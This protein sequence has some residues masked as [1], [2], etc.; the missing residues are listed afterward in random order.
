MSTRISVAELRS[1]VA[2]RHIPVVTHSGKVSKGCVFVVMPPSTP[3]GKADS[4]PG[5]ER[6]L[7]EVLKGS[8]GAVLC[9]PKHLPLLETLGAECDVAVTESMRPALGELATAYYGTDAHCP[10]VVGITGTN[11]KTTETYLMEALFRA[12]DRKVG[13]I[14]TV[15]YRWPGHEEDAPLTTPGCL[16]LH[17]MLA[18]MYTAGAEYAFMEVSSH[19][20]DQERVAGIAF[21]AALLTNLTQD[22]LDYHADMEEYFSAKELLFLS[23][24]EGGVP[25]AGKRAVANADDEYC[26]RLLARE[27]GRIGFGLEREPV[28]GSRH[29]AGTIRSLSPQG[30]RL[31]MRFEGKEWELA[32]PLVGT[33]N[34]MNLL[35]AQA[36]G[37]GLGLAPSDFDALSG[38]TGVAGR[39]ERVPG[40]LGLNVFVDYAHTPDA[41]VKA[42]SALRAAGFERVVTVFGCGGNRDRT[43]RPLMGAAVAQLTD[44]AVLTSDNP[45]DEDPEAILDDVMPGLAEC[46]RVIRQADRRAA[47]AE[48]LALIGPKDAL[49]VAGKGHETYQLIKGVKHPFS[50]Q[51]ILQELMS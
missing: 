44:I 29:L 3:R 10:T 43:K 45:R 15:S 50:D 39:L 48:A 24:A 20:L 46:G 33:F 4:A 34:V 17:A 31:A 37:L 19:A 9:H 16:E 14:G 21:S 2:A 40:K 26:R 30:V 11:G 22:H 13:V 7:A 25:L 6:Y 49:L 12:L 47:L 35:G 18:E 8:P 1:R 36:L 51:R 23:P 27:P 42:I 38:F 32:S 41:L 5:G 28:Q